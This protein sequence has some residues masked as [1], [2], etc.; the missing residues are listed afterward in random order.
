[1]VDCSQVVIPEQ[2]KMVEMRSP[3]S[4]GGI[5]IA[6]ANRMGIKTVAPNMVR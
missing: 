6:P 2:R 4:F 3:V 5:F 1:M